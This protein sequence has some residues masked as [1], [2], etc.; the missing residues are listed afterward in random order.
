MYQGSPRCPL[1][2][3][4]LNCQALGECHQAPVTR[5]GTGSKQEPGLTG[6]QW[7]AQPVTSPCLGPGKLQRRQLSVW[8]PELQ[9]WGTEHLGLEKIGEQ[10]QDTWE[11]G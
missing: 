3:E 6:Q 4:S 7:L 5:G 10:G 2:L 11:G 9:Q 1:C 8:A